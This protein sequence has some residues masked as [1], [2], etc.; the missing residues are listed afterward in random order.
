MDG[1]LAQNL[2]NRAGLGGGGNV[3]KQA[4]FLRN[5]SQG[6]DRDDLWAEGM[7]SGVT[8]KGKRIGKSGEY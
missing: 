2:S 4:E 7:I 3:A 5:F 6:S 1:D 8:D